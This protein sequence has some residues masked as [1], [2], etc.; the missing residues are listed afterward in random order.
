MKISISTKLVAA[1]VILTFLFVLGFILGKYIFDSFA[2]TNVIREAAWIILLLVGASGF[3]SSIV[4]LGYS[5][6][7]RQLWLAL[8]ALAFNSGIGLFFA[9]NME[10][11]SSVSWHI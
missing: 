6:N 8:V 4:A 2:I 10:Q 9:M 7:W 3:M 5:R 11:L 1:S